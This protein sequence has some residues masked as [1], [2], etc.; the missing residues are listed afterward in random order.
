MKWTIVT[1]FFAFTL[2]LSSGCSSYVDR[3]HQQ[4]DREYREQRGI[5]PNQNL[6]STDLSREQRQANRALSTQDSRYQPPSVQRQYGSTNN[7]D[8]RTNQSGRTRAEDLRDNQNQGSLWAGSDNQLFVQDRSRTSGDIILINVMDR[9]KSEI[10]LE[11]RRAFPPPRRRQQNENNEEEG[12][13]QQAERDVAQD[14]AE[15]R[16]HDRIS[17]VIIEKVSRDHVVLRGRK[18]VLY[19]NSKR[20]VEIQALV[21]MRDIKDDDTINSSEIIESQISIL[22]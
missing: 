13:E 14:E 7:D 1:L 8:Q 16:I 3:V 22:R 2:T 20:L 17:S 19:R 15:N 12:G 6:P 21:S 9:L 10:S 4:I 11:L 5:S 18:N